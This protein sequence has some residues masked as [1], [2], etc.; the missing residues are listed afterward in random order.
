MSLQLQDLGH[1]G[2]YIGLGDGLAGGYGQ[3]VIA[4]GP[5]PHGIVDKEMPRNF[6]HRGKKPLV[7]DAPGQKLFLHHPFAGCG[8]AIDH[9][10]FPCQE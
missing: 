10:S 8:K 6:R 7:A 3:G 9:F 1:I 5:G 4:I 2:H